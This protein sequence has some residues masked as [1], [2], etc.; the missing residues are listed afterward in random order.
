MTPQRFARLLKSLGFA[1]TVN[2][3]LGKV[4]PNDEGL[5]NFARWL[6]CAYKTAWRWANEP[7]SVPE[8]IAKLLL[9][10]EKRRMSPERVARL[11]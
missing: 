11:K 8:P 7:N 3:A 9:V 6:P 5:S 10:M 1:T 2:P 4:H